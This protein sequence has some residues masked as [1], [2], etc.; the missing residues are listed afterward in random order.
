MNTPPVFSENL[1]NQPAE[2][3]PARPR[4]INPW[5]LFIGSFVPNWLL[6]RKEV[7]SGAKLCYARLAQFAGR[8]GECYPKQ[9]TLAV[10]LG[11]SS[12]TVRA[13]LAELEKFKLIESQQKGLKMPN[14]YF[15]LNHPW[16]E[17]QDSS[18]PDRQGSSC[19]E[20]QDSSTP[21]NE[22]RITEREINTDAAAPRVSSLP[23]N[24]A[25]AVAQADMAGVPADF[26]INEFHRLE[27]TGWINGAGN[28]VCN[29]HSHIRK[30]WNDDQNRRAERRAGNR[31]T[32]T[33]RA[34]I[35][36]RN[37]A[38]ADYQQPVENL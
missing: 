19:P 30:R 24:E 11:V 18:T 26:A 35:P 9:E 12:R 21:S 7:S 6:C 31:N 22:K 23:T 8:A 28:K 13:H 2:E 1:P 3:T 15:F 36:S 34:D 16:I 10:E 38:D 29:W 5:R 4:R 20:R 14:S 32:Q 17:R 27:S 37:F 33:R 25:E